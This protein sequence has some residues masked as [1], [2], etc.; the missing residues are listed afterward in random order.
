MTI[1]TEIE[2]LFLAAK[3]LGVEPKEARKLMRAIRILLNPILSAI[4]G[5][6]LGILVGA[7]FPRTTTYTYP[8]TRYPCTRTHAIAGIGAT[9]ARKKSSMRL[10]ILYSVLGILGFI[11]GFTVS[12]QIIFAQSMA[13][14]YGVYSPK[15][16]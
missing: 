11:V 8:F 9:R 12:S 7:F 1:N 2:E 16:R 10:T 13:Y 5:L 14:M 6:S 4:L 3:Q 15:N